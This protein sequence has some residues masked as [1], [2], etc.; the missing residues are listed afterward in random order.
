MG[1][2]TVEM[3]D[4]LCGYIKNK[5]EIKTILDIGSRDAQ[6]SLKLN[7]QFPD[8]KIYAFEPTPAQYDICVNTVKEAK[9]E[10]I[11]TVFNI[12]L[13]EKDMTSKFH[14]TPGN[15]GVSSLLKP[16][17]VPFASTQELVE[18]SVQCKSGE[19][20]INENNIPV[21]DLIW[22]DAQGYELNVLKGF[23]DKIDTV[24]A[25]HTEAG[26]TPYYDGHTM[27]TDIVAYMEGRGFRL[28]SDIPDWER[29]TNLIMVNTKYE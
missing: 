3:I 1:L 19:N 9:K 6:E 5:D 23:G 18:I 24:R 27:K 17:F 4:I 25:I 20:W 14:V 13:A 28:V 21:I 2:S 16:H 29:E 12:A 10:D 26:L 8:A 11:I 15:I 22:M 7:K